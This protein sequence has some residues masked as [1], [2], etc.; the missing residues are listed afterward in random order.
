MKL[1]NAIWK[2]FLY[3]GRLNRLSDELQLARFAFVNFFSISLSGLFFFFS[4]IYTIDENIWIFLFELL[5][6]FIFVV[7]II[8]LRI[9][10]N[11]RR[12][13]NVFL[14]FLIILGNLIFIIG[15]IGNTGNVW[16]MILP[17]IVFFLK[18][19]NRGFYWNIF[20]SL[21]L[22]GNVTGMYF[23]Y[24]PHAL[25]IIVMRQTMIVYFIVTFM[26]YFI[27]FSRDR[28]FQR[29]QEYSTELNGILDNLQDIYYRTDKEGNLL[30]V[31][32]VARY[33]LGYDIDEIIGK[34]LAD[35]YYNPPEREIFLKELQNSSGVVRNYEVKMRHSNG[36]PIWV[37][38]NTS[39]YYDENGK[40]MGVEGIS[41]DI[42]ERKKYEETLRKSEDKI[43]ALLNAIP[44]VMLRYNLNGNL[45][46]RHGS[47]P[48][49]NR[50]GVKNDT[51]L[52]NYL[53][54]ETVDL[55][56][57]HGQEAEENRE[58]STFEFGKARDGDFFEYEA[59]VVSSGPGECTAIIRDITERKRSLAALEDKTR[60]LE[61]LNKNL[62]AR[63]REE[64]DERRKREQILVHQSRL[65][66]MGE[67]IGAIAHQWR[68]PINSLGLLIQDME[69]ASDYNE[70]TPEYIT[71][72]VNK[73]M[74]QI[75]YMSKTIDDFRNFFRPSK[76]KSHFQL[77]PLLKETFQIFSSQLDHHS[78]E[79]SIENEV[80]AR[81]RFFGYRNELKQVI[82][83]LISNAQNAILARRR[84]ENTPFDSYI[85][86][87]IK[88]DNNI[89]LIHLRDSG[90][91]ISPDIIDRIYDP[92]FTTRE[93]DQGTGIGL[94]MSRVIIEKNMGGKLYCQNMN[95]G[96]E[97]TMELPLDLEAS[98]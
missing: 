54:S 37:S 3:S 88:M 97:F 91:G 57:H 72:I 64:V 29:V 23:G 14:V 38:T 81:A 17:I 62:E 10:G 73:S 82:L 16:L 30:R 75:E 49:T 66:A 47:L 12:A 4:L 92:Y 33:V 51:L 63:V 86:L 7:N 11:V 18:G 24:I 78:I 95:P 25:S 39:Y 34:K 31:S 6:I 13:S 19:K 32:N 85:K 67:M 44:D 9:S 65:A 60:Q 5:T 40:V 36:H 50:P 83:N 28:A 2:D 46:D 69:D 96:V 84:I 53:D 59:R 20:T 56:I 98:P 48:V 93:N 90:C 35:L 94:Y 74:F 71:E 26:S 8:L 87:N 58:T 79:Y 45:L 21:L 22:V 55:L 41:R 43:R 1:L 77:V 76:E 52:A 27:E 42:T 15:G 70:L 89:T 61:D 80:N 68:Q